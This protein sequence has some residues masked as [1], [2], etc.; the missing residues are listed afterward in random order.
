MSEES[1][2]DRFQRLQDELDEHVHAL[3]RLIEYT[4]RRKVE[5]K[6]SLPA[7]N[8][9]QQELIALAERTADPNDK[10]RLLRI[11]EQMGAQLRGEG[12]GPPPIKNQTASARGEG[13]GPPP[14]KND[15]GAR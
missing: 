11:V 3:A 2:G 5:L 1:V 9:W 7:M 6:S 13:V 4:T 12:V 10:A 14:I 8:S 15:P